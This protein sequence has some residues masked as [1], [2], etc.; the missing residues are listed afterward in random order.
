LETVRVSKASA[1]QRAGR[2]G[3]L[4]PG[5]CLRLWSEREHQAL[6]DYQ[7]PEVKRVELSGPALQLLAAGE[8]DVAAFPWFEPPPLHAIEQA[9]ALLDRL[10]AREEGRITPLG[11]MMA[12]LPVEPRL[13]RLLVETHRLGH[14][15]RGSL[16]AALL[17]ERDPFRTE[18]AAPAQHHAPSDVLDRVCMLEEFAQSGRQPHG[19]LPLSKAAAS[20]VLR[21]ADQLARLVRQAAGRAPPTGPDA[22]EALLRGLAAAFADR[23]ARRRAPGSRRGLLVGGRGVV[24]APSSVVLEPELFVCVELDERGGQEALVRLA[25]AVLPEWLPDRFLTTEVEAEFDRQRGRVLAWH[26]TRFDGLII[27]ERPAPLPPEASHLLAAEATRLWGKELRPG[28]AEEA[29]LA[30]LALVRQYVPE[31]NLP[32]LGADPCLA[33]LPAW[34]HGKSSLAE[35]REAPLVDALKCALTPQQLAQLDQEAPERLALPSGACIRLRYAAGK[36]PVLAARIQE[37]FGL[38]ETP[39]I[40]RGRVPIVLELLAPNLRPQQITTDLS[41][42]WSNAYP[43]IRKELSRRYPKHAWPEDPLT[44]PPARPP[45][46]QK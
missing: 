28:P 3:R 25:S 27:A 13:A 16:A 18:P 42:F 14:T 7:L 1:E 20:R 43:Q 23:L 40:C 30:R 39:R 29:F 26:R 34:C 6:A 41:S 12:E 36:P 9:L 32:D 19:H 10:G 15:R 2:A 17:A 8:P 24:L 44:A 35:L 45:R 22:D 31:L 37:L 4:G 46:R 11:Q 21:A 33:A 38:R 5:L